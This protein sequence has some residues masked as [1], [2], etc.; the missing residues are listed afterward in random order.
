MA[1][2][3]AELQQ[4]FTGGF[5]EMLQRDPDEAS[6]YTGNYTV[7]PEI[8]AQTLDTKDKILRENVKVQKIPLYEVGNASSGETVII[9]GK[10]EYGY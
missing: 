4:T 8:Q 9:G 10:N 1:I 5:G 7:I 3:F 6:L 2:K